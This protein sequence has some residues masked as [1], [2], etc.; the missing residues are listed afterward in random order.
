MSIKI[1]TTINQGW[2]AYKATKKE[3]NNLQ[4]IVYIYIRARIILS[5]NLWTE[6]RLVNGSISIV[7]D[8]L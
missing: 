3:A 8:I 2:N 5:I 1:V 7:S 4:N 6:I